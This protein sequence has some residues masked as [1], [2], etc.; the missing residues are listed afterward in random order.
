MKFA[1][2]SI[3]ILYFLIGCAPK[4]DTGVVKDTKTKMDEKF[5]PL[6]IPVDDNVKIP[7]KIQKNKHINSMGFDEP[8]T[9]PT[10]LDTSAMMEKKV[11]GFRI[12]IFA[13]KD[14]EQAY[15]LKEEALQI[16]GKDTINVY[17]EFDAPYY[18]IRIGDCVTRNQAANIKNIARNKGYNKAWVVKAQ[19]YEFP[20]LLWR[21]K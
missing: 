7:E 19:V 6:S 18:K 13:T 2:F 4:R 21:I 20:E 15:L 9:T 16:F 1:I 12:Q 17:I 14:R 8:K 5:D 10:I 3:F 11:N